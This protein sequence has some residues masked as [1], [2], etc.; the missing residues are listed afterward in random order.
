VA[1]K[2][3]MITSAGAVEWLNDLGLT[4]VVIPERS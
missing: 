4:D 3:G 1:L 2:G